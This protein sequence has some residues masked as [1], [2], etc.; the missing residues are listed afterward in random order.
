MREE[1]ERE[2]A[3][4]SQRQPEGQPMT[5]TKKIL[6]GF[7]LLL[8]LLFPAA[9]QAAPTLSVT[10]TRDQATVNQGDQYV[11]YKVKVTN[12]AGL[13][14]VVGATL[15]CQPG[16]WTPASGTLTPGLS[17]QWLRN[18]LP[19]SGATAAT[20]TTSAS[21]ATTPASTV[22]DAGAAIQCQ[23]TG[24][25][26]AAGTVAVSAPLVTAPVPA[27]APPGPTAPTAASARPT[28]TGTGTATRT[29]VDPTE[30]SG[31]PTYSYQ[32]LRNGAPIAGAT[33]NTYVPVVG[34][35]QPDQDKVLQCQ[36]TGTNAGGK[37]VGISL[38][39]I[40]GAVSNP[41]VN[42]GGAANPSVANPNALSGTTTLAVS[43]P[44]G[45]RVAS[46]SGA[47][48]SCHLAVSSCTTTA[49]VGPGAQLPQLSLAFW[50]Y[51]DEVTAGTAALTFAASGGG[52]S[53]DAFA[54][55]SFTFGPAVPFGLV[56]LFARAQDPLGA[57][58]TQAGGHPFSASVG[59][60]IAK[61]KGANAGSATLVEDVRDIYTEAPPGLVGNVRAVPEQCTVVQV[62]K[63]TCP[64]AAAV[65][66]AFI[67]LAIG[68]QPSPLYNIT[69]DAGVPA[70]FAFRPTSLSSI[71]VVLKAKLRSNGDYGVTVV[72][73]VT[74]QTP[75]LLK[76]HYVTLCSFGLELSNTPPGELASFLG[77]KEST[78]PGARALPFLS[79]PTQCASE[80]PVTRTRTDSWQHPGALTSDGDPD[81]NDPSW[82]SSEAVA[83]NVTGCNQL[84]FE[85]SFEGR[86]STNVA[87]APSGLDFNL[88]IP[89]DGLED[90]EGLATAHLKRTVLTLPEGMAVNP[91]AANGLEACTSSQMGLTEVGHPGEFPVRFDAKPVK[92][93]DASKVGTVEV[94]TPILDQILKGN[95]YIAAQD[96]PSTTQP[97]AENP[98]DSLLGIYLVV[99]NDRYG[100]RA[101][102]AGRV[103]SDPVTGQLT[104]IV[105][106]NPQLPFDDLD[107]EIFKGAR[108]VLRTPSTCG[109]KTTNAEFTPWSAPDSGPPA[110]PSDSFEITTAPGGGACP[111]SPAA[112]PNSPRFSA[113]T[114]T[115]KAGAYSPFTLRL[116]RDDGSQ[117]LK[118]LEA[119][120]PPGLTGR[121]AGIPYC[122][123]AA[124]AAAISRGEPSQGRLE[125]AHPSCPAAS[126]VGSVDVAAGAGPAPFH[127]AGHAYLAGP[128]K[129][130]PL[131]LVVISPAVAGPFD[132]GAVVVRSTLNINP[133]TA[134]VSVKSDPIPTILEGIPLDV[135]SIEVAIVRNQLT[136]NPTNCEPLS[137]AGI[138]SGLSSEARVAERF[139]VG[140][141]T[142]LGFKPKLTLSLK[143][144]T[145]RGKHPALTA[146]LTPRPGDANIASVSVALP[147]S[148]FLDQAH[149]RT[150]CTRVQFAADTCPSAAVYGEATVTTPLLDYG[151]SG[152]VY[153]RSSDNPLPD[154]V[155]DLRGPAYQPVKVEAAGRVDSIRGGIR[156]TFNLVPDAPFTNFV[157]KMQGGDKG[158]LV[159]S[160]NICLKTPRATVKF[161][162][163]N[164]RSYTAHP[165]L[166]AQCG[167]KGKRQ[168]QK[169]QR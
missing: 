15:S 50:I 167:R 14:P 52:A 69:P 10:A 117:E 130:A 133:R 108:A 76:V 24:T 22:G 77:C 139:Q 144:G 9:T 160:R 132:L 154:L 134:Q 164:G 152:H 29:C 124:I 1:E 55:D 71:T 159:N 68:G 163:H 104:T 114:E 36:V 93:P 105:D 53:A 95:V 168:A 25:N 66:G 63:S 137:I 8:G 166:K 107:L 31:S 149:I 74:P 12:T 103:T 89:Q 47:G 122:P 85:P 79:N 33:S 35:G 145:A 90:P 44:A 60:D 23:V 4:A 125:Q 169:H 131:S 102:L 88:H 98:F 156:N 100:V 58:Y 37:A 121:L 146:V 101:K 41:P 87:D 17:Y 45:F 48:W 115:P 65:G 157:L 143:G 86:P 96:D 150:I 61:R 126:E 18:G 34:V 19:I 78:D 106:Q 112:L 147:H 161:T 113:G 51:P 62:E 6:G 73:P 135:R 49:S 83:P 120:L 46:A 42:A 67:E 91:S 11:S 39:S 158:L 118:G 3:Q 109:L 119:T 153:L 141:C 136:L 28:I 13:N 99:E 151:L 127:A 165:A 94:H 116:A 80:P 26:S 155:T 20:Y 7:A 142:S 129:G 140:E 138:A 5:K 30:W 84:E 54:Q 40:V 59:F 43:F 92:C 128:Y 72:A 57:D 162:A 110:T 27:P 16:T 82:K 2:K 111:T 21:S 56:G 64:D 75:A 70:E 148:E 81:L 123:E 32:W 97:G 38:N